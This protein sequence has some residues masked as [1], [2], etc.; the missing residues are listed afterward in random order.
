MTGFYTRQKDNKGGDD[1]PWACFT[2]LY[3]KI[4][5]LQ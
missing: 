2:A 4:N 5:S 3:D 1:T